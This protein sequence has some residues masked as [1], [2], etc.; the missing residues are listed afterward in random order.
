MLRILHA[1]AWGLMELQAITHDTHIYTTLIVSYA[2]TATSLPTYAAHTP[3]FNFFTSLVARIPPQAFYHLLKCAI[4]AATLYAASRYLIS[5]LALLITTIISRYTGACITE[6]QA[7]NAYIDE[8]HRTFSHF[9][10]TPSNDSGLWYYYLHTLLLAYLLPRIYR[11]SYH[12]RALLAISGNNTAI[13]VAPYPSPHILC[14]NTINEP[15]I[16]L[17]HAIL[18]QLLAGYTASYRPLLAIAM[19]NYFCRHAISQSHT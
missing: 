1:H 14:N 19:H 16:I 4:Y 17:P 18:I 3:R 11:R 10:I 8:D 9:K 12:G 15:Y 6:T 7:H 5:L 13:L 2:S